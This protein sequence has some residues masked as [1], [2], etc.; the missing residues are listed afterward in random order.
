[1]VALAILL[2]ICAAAAGACL[3]P[4]AVRRLRTPRELRGDWWTR[5]ERDFRA[6]VGRTARR[7]ANRTY[8][9]GRRHWR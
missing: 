7:Q 8:D 1:M 5:F 4:R 6:Y 2:V 3:A 9:K